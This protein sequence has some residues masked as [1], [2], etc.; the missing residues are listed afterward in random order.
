MAWDVRLISCRVGLAGRPPFYARGR[1]QVPR[2]EQSRRP[3]AAEPH[4]V[5]R[6]QS[7]SPPPQMRLQVL[8]DQAQQRIAC[9]RIEQ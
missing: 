9:F 2:S 1:V 5:L 6:I 7:P 8:K 4:R 3:S